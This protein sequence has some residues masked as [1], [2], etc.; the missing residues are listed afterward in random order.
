MNLY[1]ALQ[2]CM[3]RELVASAIGVNHGG[4][5]VALAKSALAGGLG[6]EVSLAGL[7]G[8]ASR[9]D[10]AL[11]SESQG[12]VLATIASADKKEFE[13]ALAGNAFACVGTVREDD[14]ILIR[15]GAGNQ[16]AA[17]RLG[18]MLEAYRAPLRGF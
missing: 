10:F 1:R 11:Y 3:A 6:I 13:A 8:R 5:A 12:R 14:Q 17:L 4:L 7:P 2:E 15:G 16:I 18:A 9:D